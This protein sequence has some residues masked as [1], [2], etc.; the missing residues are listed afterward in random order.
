MIQ[1]GNRNENQACE[2]GGRPFNEID[3]IPLGHL[4][5]IQKPCCPRAVP[6]GEMKQTCR[7]MHEHNPGRGIG[8][9]HDE[10][11]QDIVFG[12]NDAIPQR[13]RS[14]L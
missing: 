6:Q 14:A 4:L 3:L 7:T 8:Q 11:F 1:H 13:F 12:R 2:S 5:G 9:Q 10:H